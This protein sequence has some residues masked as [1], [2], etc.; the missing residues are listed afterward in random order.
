MKDSW[1]REPFQKTAPGGLGTLAAADL[2]LALLLPNLEVLGDGTS[3]SRLGLE[4]EDLFAQAGA[5][6]GGSGPVYFFSCNSK[7]KRI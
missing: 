3:S 7:K 1:T 5:G 2:E 4:D 6:L